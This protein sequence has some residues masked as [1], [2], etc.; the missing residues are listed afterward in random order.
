MVSGTIAAQLLSNLIGGE[1]RPARQGG[2]FAKH[3]PASGR[4]LSIGSALVR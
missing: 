2:T 1:R 3:S 4:P